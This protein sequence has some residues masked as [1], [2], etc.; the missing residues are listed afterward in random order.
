MG[1]IIF[2]K[3]KALLSHTL[4]LIQGD[5]NTLKKEKHGHVSLMEIE[6]NLIWTEKCR[7]I[8]IQKEKFL[9]FMAAFFY[10]TGHLLFSFLQ[11]DQRASPALLQTLQ[12]SL[13]RSLFRM[14]RLRAF[15]F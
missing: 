3:C 7:R 15:H 2:I 5:E 6:N 13:D 9:E 10:L 11:K 8:K 12:C 14:V 4:A 1:Y